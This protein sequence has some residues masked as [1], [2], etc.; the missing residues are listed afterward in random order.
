M[1]WWYGSPMGGWGALFMTITTV[2]FWGLII[3]GV[4]ALF[5]YVNRGDRPTMSGFTPE[6]VLAERFARGEIDEQEYRQRLDTLR[7][8]SRPGVRP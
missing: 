5:R 1:M 3:L 2:L 8:I 4:I 6:Q 7:G